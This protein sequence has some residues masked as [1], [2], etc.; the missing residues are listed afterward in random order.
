MVSD[1]DYVN[2][3]ERE[4]EK[5]NH[6]NFYDLQ[7]SE[8]QEIKEEAMET[9]FKNEPERSPEQM[10][11]YDPRMQN[12]YGNYGGASRTAPM[13]PQNMQAGM[14]QGGY[15]NR[16]T[17]S[18]GAMMGR[19]TN[20][21]QGYNKNYPAGM[22]HD[23]HYHHGYDHDNYYSHDHHMMD[24]HGYSNY[25]ARP[26][27]N[28]AGFGGYGR[29]MMPNAYGRSMGY[30]GYDGYGGPMGYGRGM[31]YGGP[32]GYDGYGGPM[33]YGAPM[34]LRGWWYG[35]VMPT[36][37]QNPRV[38]NFFRIIGMVTVGMVVAPS[39]ARALRPVAVQAVQ[40]V[41]GVT[42]EVKGIFS[43]AKEDIEDIFAE[44]KW[45]RAGMDEEQKNGE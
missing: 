7:S 10:H 34:G 39:L 37:F 15:N 31:G 24:Y 29:H 43:D 12:N 40:G 25:G 2:A 32:M 42:E 27:Y 19:N 4:P 16:Q 17:M 5:M 18:M 8:Y 13:R 20:P 1:K 9:N 45:D 21:Y 26:G 41:M 30:G 14:P 22:E 28:Q 44:A 3:K 23:D 33:G 11:A 36:L 35:T 38:N 6:Q